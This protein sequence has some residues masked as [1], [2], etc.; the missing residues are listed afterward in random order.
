[1]LRGQ[2]VREIKGRAELNTHHQDH[3]LQA[4]TFQE[5]FSVFSNTEDLSFWVE[6]NFV[7]IKKQLKGVKSQPRMQTQATRVLL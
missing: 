2:H 7:I 4:W 6:I 5:G 3:S 1:M